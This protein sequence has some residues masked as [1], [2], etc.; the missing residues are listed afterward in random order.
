MLGGD[1]RSL[2]VNMAC[3]FTTLH[4]GRIVVR[5]STVRE[6][7]EA[8]ARRQT[9]EHSVTAAT[10]LDAVRCAARSA[11]D[12]T[13]KLQSQMLWRAKAWKV[14]LLK[15]AINCQRLQATAFCVDAIRSHEMRFDD[16]RM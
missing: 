5:T 13:Q 4:F 2:K 7:S 3:M 14:A 15:L 9:L 1:G 12:I 10:T 16:G 8:H 11:A 6:E